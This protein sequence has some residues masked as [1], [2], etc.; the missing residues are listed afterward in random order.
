MSPENEADF[1]VLF[2]L[3]TRLVQSQAGK[4]IPQGMEWCNDAQILALKFWRHVASVDAI[5]QPMGIRLDG[6]AVER[7]VDHSS[8]NVI[9]RAALETYLTFSHI[10]GGSDVA[11]CEFRHTIWRYSGLVDRQGFTA[12][13]S[14]NKAK[15]I[16]EKASIDWLSASIQQSAL[17]NTYSKDARGKMLKGEWRGGKA[18]TKIAVDAGFHEKHIGDVYSYLCAYS[19]SSWL[20][21][22]Q[23]RD[24]AGTIQEQQAMADSFVST[25]I[26]LLSFFV[27]DY[28]SLFPDS[29]QLA[30]LDASEAQIQRRWHLT[31]DKMAR[32]YDAGDAATTAP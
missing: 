27:N 10:Y 25:A 6:S 31:A 15:Q 21:V 13:N 30:G 18:W 20:S 26:V 5:R 28:A 16:E 14:A 7:F 9:V 11:V 4:T 3:F 32:K 2:G 17:W 24:A 22:I 1:A 29:V 12:T 19:H 8:V 23:I